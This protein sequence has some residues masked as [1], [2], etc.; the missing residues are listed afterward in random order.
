MRKH[1]R[2]F[3]GLNKL[4]HGFR[5]EWPSPSPAYILTGAAIVAWA[6]YT[7]VLSATVSLSL[8]AAARDALVSVTTG[9]GLAA[10]V[11]AF[12]KHSVMH[13]SV[14]SQ[15]AMHALLA[16]SFAI[17]WYSLIVMVFAFLSGL[18]G[19]GFQ[20]TPF[21]RAA[22]A[23]QT[24][25][26]MTIYGLVAAAC[27]ALRG[28]REAV[29]VT[30]LDTPPL[31]R[32]LTK[33]GDEVRPV[34][35]REIVSITGAQDYSEVVTQSGGRHLV[36]L[37]L[38]EFEARLDRHRFLRIHRSAIINLDHL[39]HLESAGG[40]RMLISMINGEQLRSSRA[41]SQLLRSLIV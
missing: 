33:V 7:V 8:Y 22:F 15:L 36:R 41:G 26:G 23:W 28:G 34:E 27:Y 38:N 24:F 19:S 3:V 5:A 2:A 37:S 30:I 11:H 17:T 32:Y 20:I 6:I 16:P 10:I 4:L 1:L 14:Q 39:A 31:E 12:L 21:P 29:A 18:N 25:Q 35:V 40:G 9:A 13:N